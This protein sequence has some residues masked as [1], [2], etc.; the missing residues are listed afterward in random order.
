MEENREK[1]SMEKMT[2]K[3]ESIIT[4]YVIKPKEV[5]LNIPQL[6]KL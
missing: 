2:E 3:F 4:P 1:Y 5:K 6:T